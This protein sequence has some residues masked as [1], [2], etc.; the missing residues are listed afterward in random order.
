MFG[1]VIEERSEPKHL[2]WRA[3]NRRVTFRSYN[4]TTS[5]RCDDDAGRRG[6]V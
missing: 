1:E 4:L 3:L 5:G 6:Q 2:Y